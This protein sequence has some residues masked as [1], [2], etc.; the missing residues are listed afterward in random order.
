MTIGR[1]TILF[2]DASCLI[3]AAGS[4]TGG[5]GFLLSICAKGL[6]RAAVSHPVLLEAQSNIETKLG[7]AAVQRYINLL[8]IVPFSLARLPA[9]EELN[10]L[11]LFI[12]SKDLHVV[13]AAVEVK[14]QFLLTLDKKLIKEI[15]TTSLDVQAS[16]PG[17]FIKKILPGYQ[18]HGLIEN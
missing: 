6:L 5:S 17:D 14:A 10:R 9:Q 16:T 13:A 8:T 15:N 7:G 11:K 12:N 3:A 1:D 4:P 2:F 18:S